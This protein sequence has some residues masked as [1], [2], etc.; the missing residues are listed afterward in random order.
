MALV[1]DTGI[2]ISDPNY[3]NAVALDASTNTL[4]FVDSSNTLRYLDL[5]NPTSLG[6]VTYNSSPA[7]T[8]SIDAQPATGYVDTALQFD[9]ATF[10]AGAYWYIESESPTLRRAVLDATTRTITR[11]DTFTLV[12]G[13]GN[14]VSNATNFFKFG[15]IASDGQ[16]NI[17]GWTV[18][19]NGQSSFFKVDV[20]PTGTTPAE[21]AT[22]G[23][24][25]TLSVISNNNFSMQ[26]TYAGNVLYGHRTPQAHLRECGDAAR[27]RGM[28]EAARFGSKAK[29]FVCCAKHWR[30]LHRNQPEPVSVF[31]LSPHLR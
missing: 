9:N 6:T 29:A 7:T 28:V 8:W 20:T 27:W 4:Y 16:G 21:I 10:Y 26:L 11:I 3:G 17:Y 25:L 31:V 1:Y 2:A 30:V 22:S 5:S 14:P 13:S 23:T 19:T 18:P 15:D 12:D 24:N